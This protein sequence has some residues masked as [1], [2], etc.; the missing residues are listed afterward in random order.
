MSRM[1]EAIKRVLTTGE[2]PDVPFEDGVPVPVAFWEGIVLFLVRR[3]DGSYHY[4]AAEHEGSLAGG[5]LADDL[6]ERD[7]LYVVGEVGVAG[8]AALVG[9][10]PDGAVSVEL[11]AAGSRAGVHSR[12]GAFV[13]GI[14]GVSQIPSDRVVAFDGAGEPLDAAKVGPP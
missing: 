12:T 10:A 13:I 5:P 9:I 7:G 14:A 4:L 8:A 2:L 6:P 11:E 1:D 3:G